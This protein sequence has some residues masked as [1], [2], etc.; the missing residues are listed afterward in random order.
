MSQN[1]EL[2]TSPQGD[3][4]APPDFR[5]SRVFD[6]PKRLVFAAWS[7]A[8]DVARWFTPS[9]LT[10]PRCEVDLR[11]GG[12]FRVVMKMPDGP[13]F[14][15]DAIFTEVVPEARI[16]FR[17]TIHG[18]LEVLT[19]VTF[20]EEAGETTLVVHQ[21]YSR[22]DGAVQGAAAGWTRTLDQLAAQLAAQPGEVA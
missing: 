14:P 8:E 3:G 10:T 13:E 12:V 1:N 9:P 20:S 17:A 5:M 21:V 16:V 6:A 15:M 18:G 11:T 22:D 7:K 4:A 2:G 19:T